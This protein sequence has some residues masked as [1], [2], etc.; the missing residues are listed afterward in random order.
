MKKRFTFRGGIH[1]PHFKEATENV[2]VER[3]KEPQIVTIPLH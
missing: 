3:A 1:P 2:A